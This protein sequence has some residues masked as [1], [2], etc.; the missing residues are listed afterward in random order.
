M[1]VLTHEYSNFPAQT[2]SLHN[3]LNVAEAPE[4]V[5]TVISNIKELISKGHYN[6]A[7][8]LFSENKTVLANYYI[9]SSVINA[10]EEEIRNL[11]IYAKQQQ[12][13]YY[14]SEEEPNCNI[15][16]VWIGD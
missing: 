8:Q 4:S 2:Y 9:D 15:G 6:A 3:F 1:A 5:V 10:I 11:E 13:A 7:A 14:Y 12:Q 16:D